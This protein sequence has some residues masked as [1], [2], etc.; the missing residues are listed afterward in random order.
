MIAVKFS[1]MRSPA[2]ADPKNEDLHLRIQLAQSTLAD[3]H[4]RIDQLKA[5]LASAK[6]SEKESLQEQMDLL[7]AQ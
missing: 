6:A 5:R 3:E 2:E 4:S 7:E 1:S